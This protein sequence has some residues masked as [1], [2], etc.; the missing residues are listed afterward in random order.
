VYRDIEGGQKSNPL[1]IKLKAKP[2]N[3]CCW[4]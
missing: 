1:D 4:V 3:M 2:K